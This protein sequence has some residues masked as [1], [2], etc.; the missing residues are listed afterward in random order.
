MPSE[1]FSTLLLHWGEAKEHARVTKLATNVPNML[2][3]T[4]SVPDGFEE[5][6]C[7]TNKV[8]G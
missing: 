8:Q 4:S 6:S 1:I 3:L 5:K 7:L 2:V